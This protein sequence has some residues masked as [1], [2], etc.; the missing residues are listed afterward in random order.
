ML[1]GIT[2]RVPFFKV[3]AIVQVALL[4]RRHIQRL[5][6]REQR[7]AASILSHPHHLSRQERRELRELAAKLEPRM[8]FGSAADQFSPVPLPRWVTGVPKKEKK[9]K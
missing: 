8:F 2:K 4:A 7:R 1:S 3:I 5:N 6:A 9:K